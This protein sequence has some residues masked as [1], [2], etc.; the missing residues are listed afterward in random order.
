MA[1]QTEVCSLAA[2][3][4]VIH[5]RENSSP[6]LTTPCENPCN[7]ALFPP[8]TGV[9][10][11]EA[12]LPTLQDPSRT[13]ARFPRAH[14]NPRWTGCNQRAPGQRTGT[15]GSLKPAR[16]RLPRKAALRGK[17]QFTGKFAARR[18]GKFFVVLRRNSQPGELARLGIVIGR[19]TAPRSVTRSLMKRIVRELFRL[20][21]DQLGPV[22]V[23]VRVRQPAGRQDL[24][25][26]RY[27]L[28]RLL[29]ETC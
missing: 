23:I 16:Y 21:R 12:H 9:Q 24:A 15:S 5:R 20:L 4:Q 26:A 19:Q 11:Y 25:A 10:N 18:Q 2:S 22:D 28:E 3:V 29:R 8:V 17:A 1:L 7:T 27:E 6:R 14:E 13:Y